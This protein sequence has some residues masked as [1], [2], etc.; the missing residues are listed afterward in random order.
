MGRK[1][2]EC[3]CC[4]KKINLEAQDWWVYLVNGFGE[5]CQECAY[6]LDD[7]EE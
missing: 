2:R 3:K 5:V 1:I 4:G 7:D 6:E